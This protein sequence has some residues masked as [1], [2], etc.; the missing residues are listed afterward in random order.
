MNLKQIIRELELKVLVG[1]EHL[2]QDVTGGYVSDILSDVLTYAQEGDI[3]VTIQTHLNIVPISSMKGISAIILPNNR[4]PDEETLEKA[5][6][7]KMPILGSGKNAFQVVGGL[8]QLGI[9]GRDEN[10]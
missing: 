9:R 6:E 2:E 1:E 5:F 4:I 10:V 3:W 8:F 7:E